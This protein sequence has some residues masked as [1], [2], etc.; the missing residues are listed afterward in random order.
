MPVTYRPAAPEDSYIVFRIWIQ[1]ISHLAY[2]MGY[3]PSPP[4]DDPQG[5]AAAWQVRRPLFEHLARTAHQFWLA[6]SEDEVIGY[7]RSVLHGGMLD[8]TEF[9]VLPGR[10][11]GGVGRELLH[12]A[13][14]SQPADHR[15]IIATADLRAVARYLKAGVYARFPIYNFSREPR[16]DLP[17]SDVDVRRLTSS[18]EDLQILSDL[19]S[20]LLGHTRPQDHTFWLSYKQGC[21]FYRRDELLGYGYIHK[22]GGPFL[23]S[24]SAAYPSV[25]SAAERLSASHTDRF[26]LE[27]P[28]INKHAVDWLLQN[29]YEI[30]PFFAFFMSDSPWGS[31]ENYLIANPPFTV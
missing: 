17:P 26:Y 2:Q 28:L 4:E 10:Q 9:F 5:L 3:S 27:V 8:L 19:D 21:L 16:P 15:T 12:R 25:L 14:T 6:C 23:L 7:A 30:S 11:S 31:F 24:D 18:P 22:E 13:F 29:G 1:T 20:Q